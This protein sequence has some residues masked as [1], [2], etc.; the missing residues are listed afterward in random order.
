MA[1]PAKKIYAIFLDKKLLNDMVSS[2]N[3]QFW[4]LFWIVFQISS[5]NSWRFLLELA[6]SCLI[7]VMSSVLVDGYF[8]EHLFDY[9]LS[10]LALFL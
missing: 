6:S 2:L 5:L 4:T 8:C 10:T 1:L 9:R 3:T 7:P